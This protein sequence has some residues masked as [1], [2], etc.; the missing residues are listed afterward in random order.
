VARDVTG[1]EKATLGD[2]LKKQNTAQKVR[3]NN[4]QSDTAAIFP[5]LTPKAVKRVLEFF[6]AQIS[7]D[8][9]RRAYM[10]AA[11]RFA[12]W[13]AGNGI[14]E[15][16]QV[17]P[18]HVA[19]LYQGSVGR[20]FVAHS[21]AAPGRTPDAVRLATAVEAAIFPNRRAR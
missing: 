15:L 17:Q 19:R 18:F 6:T 10:N 1:N 20:A 2:I 4:S 3:P 21:Q 9:T 8:H 13:C 5:S 7:N 11:R 14:Q 16:S 12:D